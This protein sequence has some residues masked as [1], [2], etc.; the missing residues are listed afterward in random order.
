MHKICIQLL[1]SVNIG[2]SPWQRKLSRNYVVKGALWERR[3]KKGSIGRKYTEESAL[4]SFQ[5]QKLGKHTAVIYRIYVSLLS[6]A[7]SDV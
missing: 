3:S 2:R 5:G 7:L 6:S 4:F 1:I